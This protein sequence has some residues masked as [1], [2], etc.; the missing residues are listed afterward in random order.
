KGLWSH[1]QAL[2][3]PVT[4]DPQPLRRDPGPDLHPARGP[5]PKVKGKKPKS[6]MEDIP[7]EGEPIESDVQL[8]TNGHLLPLDPSVTAPVS[9]GDDPKVKAKR[10]WTDIYTKRETMY[11]KNL[12]PFVFV[13]TLPKRCQGV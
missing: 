9:S 10:L 13:K 8:I 12:K 11:W 7:Q 2:K 1:S 5:S 6:V 3:Q 4:S